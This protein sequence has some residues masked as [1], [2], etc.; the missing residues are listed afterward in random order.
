[1][2]APKHAFE[3]ALVSFETANWLPGAEYLVAQA[4]P[5]SNY[6]GHLNFLGGFFCLFLF[7]VLFLRQTLQL[8]SA[9]PCDG[10]VCMGDVRL[11][12][13]RMHILCVRAFEFSLFA[14]AR[15]HFTS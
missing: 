12:K 3:L 13:R 5:M 7:A 14:Y 8:L 9:Y 4:A 2:H 11:F 15:I 1:M 10:C 6:I